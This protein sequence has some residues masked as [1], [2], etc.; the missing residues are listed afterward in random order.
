MG[1]VIHVGNFRFTR[2]ERLENISKIIV[3]NIYVEIFIWFQRLAARV[4]VKN[5]FRP[6]HK[7]FEALPPHL[8][9][10]YRNLHFTACAERKDSRCIRLAELERNVRTAFSNQTL[11]DMPCGKELSFTPCQWGVVHKK[12]HLNG[13]RININKCERGSFLKIGK[14]FANRNLIKTGQTNDVA[15]AGMFDFET[16]QTPISK[17]RGNTTPFA[18]SIFV[19]ADNRV[20]NFH[21]SADDSTKRKASQ[22][23]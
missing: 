1:L 4:L 20:P 18:P 8:F 15:C 16:V 6:G 11:L 7:Q 9:H 19:H 22:V 5:D 21:P 14:C 10:K 2:G 3:R 12:I 13:G 17:K 23:I